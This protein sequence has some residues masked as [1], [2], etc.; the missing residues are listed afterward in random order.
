MSSDMINTMFG[1]SAARALLV[2]RL[3]LATTTA[4]VRT[5][6]NTFCRVIILA[7][8]LFVLLYPSSANLDIDRAKGTMAGAQ[9]GF[10]FARTV[11]VALFLS[12]YE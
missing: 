6:E 1:A 4:V 5:E 7:C 2:A 9:D 11:V 10:G 8:L 12:F 3:R